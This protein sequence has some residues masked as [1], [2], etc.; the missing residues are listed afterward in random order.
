MKSLIVLVLNLYLIVLLARLVVDFVQVFSRDWRPSGPLLVVIE[1]VYTVTDPP[2]KAL[3]RVIPS[4]R[5]GNVALDLSFM[6]LVLGI[7]LLTNLVIA[8]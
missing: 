7:S 2:L 4:V 6:V 5:L 8:I 1:G 3:R